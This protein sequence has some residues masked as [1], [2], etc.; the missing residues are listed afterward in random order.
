[1]LPTEIKRLLI[2]SDAA[3]PQVNGVVRTIGNTITQLNKMG[4][5]VDMLTPDQF[6]S[7]PCPSYPDIRL[8]LT[9][10]RHVE[11]LIR[12]L[13]PDAMHISTEGPLG[14]AARNAALRNGWQFTTAFHTRFPEYVHARIGIPVSWGYALL[15]KFH[16]AS[17]AVL[18]PTPTIGQ[19][20]IKHGFTNIVPWTHGV[21]HQIF[22]PRPVLKLTHTS[23]PIFLY[24]GRLA[25]EKNVEAFLKLDLPGEKWVAGVGPLGSIIQKKYPTARYIGVL[26]QDALAELY[27]QADVFVFPSLTDTFG[28]VMVEA[29][30]CGLPV[31]AFPVPGPL[32]VIGASA[33]GVMDENLKRACMQAL[34]ISRNV[35]TMHARTFSWEIATQLMVQALVHRIAPTPDEIFEKLSEQLTSGAPRST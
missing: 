35:A 18:A 27:S 12:D 9:T 17:S 25:V 21:D 30:A 11:K 31:A 16:S 29:M 33:A 34:K 20:L 28:L 26:S 1:M 5:D 10:S 7:V 19:N 32:D 4:I 6:K 13:K 15:R 3:A 22:Y 2:V 14:W 8:S 23:S 24:V